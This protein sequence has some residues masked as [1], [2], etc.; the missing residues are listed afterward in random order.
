M[1]SVLCG[2]YSGDTE[3]A[4]RDS[5]C[6]TSM[7]LDSG[8][9]GHGDQ[10]VFEGIMVGVQEANGSATQLKQWIRSANGGLCMLH[11]NAALFPLMIMTLYA[12]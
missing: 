12:A 9:H 2:N 7:F 6:F 5:K 8:F 1:R 10:W 11:Y 3:V 4:H